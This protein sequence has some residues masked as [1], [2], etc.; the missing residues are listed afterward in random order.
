VSAAPRPAIV[1]L[2]ILLVIGCGAAPARATQLAQVIEVID[3]DTIVVL[4]ERQEQRVRYIGID[5]P[6][7]D[8]EA[9]AEESTSANE[10]LVGGAQVWLER[11]VSETDRFDRLL[12][13]VWLRSGDNGEW[14]NVNAEIVRLGLARATS[15]PP[16]TRYDDVYA[17]AQAEAA[18]AGVGLWAVPQP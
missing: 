2:L 7:H 10:D 18:Q 8:T 12:R 17:A 5:A 11:D 6:E 16:D 9:L 1:A 14:L 3:G 15:Y 4:V 13:H